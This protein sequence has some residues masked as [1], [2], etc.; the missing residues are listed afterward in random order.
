MVPLTLFAYGARRRRF[1]TLGLLQ[2]VAPSGQFLIGWLIY[3]EPFDQGRAA[4]F[5]LIWL[6]LACYTPDT[7]RSGSRAASAPDLRTPKAGEG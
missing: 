4:A 6:G 3:K 5:A 2:Y 7:I 1:T